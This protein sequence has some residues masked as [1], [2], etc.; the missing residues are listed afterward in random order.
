MPSFSSQL[1]LS[2]TAKTSNIVLAEIDRVKGAFKVYATANAMNTTSINYFT[3]KQIVYVQDSASLYQATITAADYVSTFEDTIAF[4]SFSFGGGGGSVPSGTVSSSAQITSVINDSYISASAA[5]SGFGSGGGGT[6]DFTQLTNVPSGL[7]SG[8][9]QVTVT[10]SQIS[11]LQSYLTSVPAGT[12]SGSA[13]SVTHITSADL[14]MGG[15]KV[16]FG[17]VYSQLSDLP[18][19]STYHGMFAHVHATGLGYFAHSGNWIPLISNSSQI[20]SGLDG[21]DITVGKLTANEVVTNIVSQS[22]A[23]ATGS[24][25]FGDEITDIHQMTGSLVISGSISFTG[26]LDGGTF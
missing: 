19:A 24:T 17:N 18:S 25:I 5:S 23:F 12:V 10:E 8:S 14:D 2:S 21:Q 9:S 16:L 1:Q 3:D 20:V 13:Q 11:D 15:N 6:S 4:S 26:E 22:I 7:V